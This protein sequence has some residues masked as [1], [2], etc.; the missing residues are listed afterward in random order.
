[1][2]AVLDSMRDR[3][4]QMTLALSLNEPLFEDFVADGLIG[5]LGEWPNLHLERIPTMEHVFRSPV[6][7][8]M[9]HE[10]LDGALARTLGSLLEPPAER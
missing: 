7:Q 8:R 1:V 5:R 9:A 4:V 10:V 6:S 3:G 2:L